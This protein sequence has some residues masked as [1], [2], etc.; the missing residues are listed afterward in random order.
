MQKN[1]TM[2]WGLIIFLCII[3]WPVGL[4]FLFK[5]INADKSATLQSSKKVFIISY[6]LIAMGVIYLAGSAEKEPSSSGVAVLFI[7]GGIWLFVVARKMKANGE[8]YKKYISIVINQRLFD[9]DNIASSVG[10]TYEVAR[11]DLQ[12]M[13]DTGY[14]TDAFINASTREIVLVSNSSEVKS[15]V[16]SKVVACKSCGANNSIIV[17]QNNIC[18]Y[19]GSAVE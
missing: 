19:C 17:G 9:I 8:K 1:K 14:F 16:Q 6:V 13:I 5:K 2:S 12:K 15:Q 3:F 18:E 4:F 10:V 7:I 11:R